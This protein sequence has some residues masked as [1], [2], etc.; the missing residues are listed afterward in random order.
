V[1]TT[2]GVCFHY[3]AR[4]ETALGADGTSPDGRTSWGP[5]DEGTVLPKD[6]RD[7]EPCTRYGCVGVKGRGNIREGR[8]Q[9]KSHFLN[10]PAIEPAHG[11]PGERRDGG[12]GQFAKKDEGDSRPQPGARRSI[13]PKLESMQRSDRSEFEPRV[14]SDPASLDFYALLKIEPKVEKKIKDLR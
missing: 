3:L 9:V 10:D 13:W 1:G 12:E 5:Q 14:R 4:R 6:A 11:I 7:R 2:I 8:T